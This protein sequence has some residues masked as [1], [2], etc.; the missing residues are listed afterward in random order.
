MEERHMP[1]LLLGFL[2]QYWLPIAIGVA[3][4]ALMGYV[5]VLHMEIDHYKAKAVTMQL[6]IDAAAVK[7]KQLEVA[8]AQITTKYHESLANQFK[9][10][11]AQGQ[12]IHE[13][14]TKNETAK[15]I[16]IPPD[17]L[18]LFNDSKP[19]LKLKDPATTVKRNDGRPSPVE[20][21]PRFAD[22]A[23]LAYEHSLS[24][25]LDISAYN[26]GNHVKCI[27]TVHEWQHFWIDYTETYKAVN[28][29]P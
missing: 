11:D 3:C 12:A 4:L 10:Q 9:M 18:R 16:V 27:A 7:E 23:P 8:A 25:L 28:V 6:A 2:K 15:H 17:V 26:D 29:G 22:D 24:E 1:I 21:D 20:E 5:K 19:S 13:R 14:I